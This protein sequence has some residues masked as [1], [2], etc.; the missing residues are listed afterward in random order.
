MRRL[1]VLLLIGALAVVGLT[2]CGEDERRTAAIGTSAA[3]KLSLRVDSFTSGR[4]VRQNAV[5]YGRRRTGGTPPGTQ[6]DSGNPGSTCTWEYFQGD[7]PLELDECTV[8]VHLAANPAEGERVVWTGCATSVSVC[9]V[10]LPGDRSVHARFTYSKLLSLTVVKQGNASGSVSQG[11]VVNGRRVGGTSAVTT[12]AAAAEPGTT[13]DWEYDKVCPS[14]D[15]CYV[16]VFLTGKPAA[17]TLVNWTG[18]NKTFTHPTDPPTYKT[19]QVALTGTVKAT[20]VVDPKAST[21]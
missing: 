18:C 12:C 20:F 8:S 11:S 5:Y 3:A 21:G 17:G 1:G 9:V 13:C 4:W 14:S 15:P 6:C 19:C 16:E 7:C 10:E 2:A